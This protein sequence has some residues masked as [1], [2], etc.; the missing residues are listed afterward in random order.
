MLQHDYEFS[1]TNFSKKKYNKQC[2]PK[3]INSFDALGLFDGSPVFA[4]PLNYVQ[5]HGNI[6][7]KQESYRRCIKIYYRRSVN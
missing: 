6:E 1:E 3:G 7:E 2:P 5:P 4:K